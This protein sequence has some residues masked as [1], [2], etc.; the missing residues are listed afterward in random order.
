MLIFLALMQTASLAA[1]ARPNPAVCAQ[2]AERLPLKPPTATRRT[3]RFDTR[4][5]IK[6]LFS[7]TAVTSFGAGPVDENDAKAWQ[8][9]DTMCQTT[10][11]GGECLLEGPVKFF[12]TF[13]ENKLAW[14]PEPGEHFLFRVRG[15]I[16]EC[17]D[18]PAKPRAV[19]D[20]R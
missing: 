19:T 15:T 1:P 14:E 7:G 11:K 6:G 8:R 18:M 4:G 16:L 5:G 9:A 13:D 17:E 2:I 3:W 12:L 20:V 10:P